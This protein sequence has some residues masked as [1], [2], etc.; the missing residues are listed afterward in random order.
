MFITSIDASQRKE[1]SFSSQF[2]RVKVL[3]QH[4]GQRPVVL[5]KYSRAEKKDFTLWGRSRKGGAE[6]QGKVSPGFAFRRGYAFQKSHCCH[7]THL[8]KRN[9]WIL[10]ERSIPALIKLEKIRW[11][12][13]T[14][15][16]PAVRSEWQGPVSGVSFLKSDVLIECLADP[17]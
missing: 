2:W 9:D 12:N 1:N 3:L 16:C 15:N 13:N 7:F 6:M 11:Y 14:A 5:S 17:N 10:P 4:P 8:T